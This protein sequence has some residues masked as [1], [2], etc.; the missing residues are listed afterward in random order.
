MDAALRGARFAGG[1]TIGVLP[2]DTSKHASLEAE[3][4]IVTGMGEARNVVNVLTSR[5][6]FVCGMSA[7]TASEVAVALKRKR[8]I[9]LINAEIE[10]KRFWTWLDGGLLQFA[11]TPEQAIELAQRILSPSL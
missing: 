6:L 7:G 5:L 1:L 11:S 2:D 9:I 3:I 10:V 8:P 4:V